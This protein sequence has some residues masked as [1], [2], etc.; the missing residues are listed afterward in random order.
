MIVPNYGP[1]WRHKVPKMSLYLWYVRS[2]HSG[3]FARI[4]VAPWNA[5]RRPIRKG[6]R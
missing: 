3:T 6:K 2:I 1:N 4:K 5:R